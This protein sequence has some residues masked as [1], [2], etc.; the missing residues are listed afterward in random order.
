MLVWII[1]AILSIILLIYFFILCNDVHKIA[2]K[3]NAIGSI[4]DAILW[5]KIGDKQKAVELY[6]LHMMKNDKRGTYVGDTYIGSADE[7]AKLLRNNFLT[8]CKDNKIPNE[9]LFDKK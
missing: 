1:S 6:K 2:K 9:Y 7:Y 5:A 8:F 3:M 4:D